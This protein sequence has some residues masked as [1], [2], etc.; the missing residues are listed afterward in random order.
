[1]KLN[2]S[3]IYSKLKG[4]FMNHPYKSIF[5][6]IITIFALSTIASANKCID[7]MF[8]QNTTHFSDVEQEFHRDSTYFNEGGNEWTHKYV[9]ESGKL[10]EMRYDPK[11]ENEKI[12]ILRFYYDVDESVLKKTGAEYIISKCNAHDTLCYEQKLYENGVYEGVA[13]SKMLPN[14]A[15]SETI[16]SSTH[17][18]T[19]YF[20]KSDSI[21]IKEYFDYNTDSV[22]TSQKFY[23]ADPNDELKCYQYDA[24]GQIDYTLLYKP[25]EKGYS[26]S[27]DGGSYFREF[28]F[29]KTAKPSSIRKTLKHAKIPPKARYFDLLGRFKFSK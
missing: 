23:A 1:M 12:N 6:T 18:F 28:F 29:V 14:Y 24:K 11:N 2:F 7:A 20:I 25:N 27:I 4:G 5:L 19:E 9:Y 3:Y 8:Q 13:I 26:I 15:S 17:W 22:R 10:V 21:I 16:E